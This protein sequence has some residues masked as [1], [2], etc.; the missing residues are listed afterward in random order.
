[1]PFVLLSDVISLPLRIAL[2]VIFWGYWFR[3]VRMDWVHRIAWTLALLL[4]I[5]T[6]MIRPPLFG[7]VVSVHAA[8]YLF[9][10]LQTLKLGMAVLLFAIT[11][12]GIRKQKAEGWLALSAVLLV[13]VALYQRELHVFLHVK[14]TFEAWGFDIHL[15]QISTIVSLFLITV[16]LVRRYLHTQQKRE[17]WKVEIEQARQVQHVLI[18]DEL[19]RIAGFAIES[20]YR[21]AREVGGDFFQ[22]MPGQEIGSALILVG[23][24]TGKGLQAGMLVAVIVG[25]FRTAAQYHSDPLILMNTLNDQLSIRGGSSATCLI[26]RIT[27]DGEVTLANA[28]HLAPYLNGTEMEMEGALPIGVL[29]QADFTVMHFQLAPGDTLM[30]MSD[31]V[32]E[33]QDERK[34]LFGFDRIGEMLQRPISAAALASA[35]QAFGQED[36]ILV[37]R[38]QRKV[39]SDSL[40]K[41]GTIMATT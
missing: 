28:G 26:L 4:M 15:G 23:D 13:A 16:M 14:T 40:R 6:A 12:R 19:P 29:P 36:D 11:V 27:A 37:L 21:P 9:P 35:A 33:A 1:M 24:V 10:I 25:A 34:Q 30:L 20:E 18:P 31:G 5:G 38:I 7:K 39:S 41:A 32:A 22:I 3:I 17:Q 8:V 2:W